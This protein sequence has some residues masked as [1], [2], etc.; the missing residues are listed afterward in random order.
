G[1]SSRSASRISAAAPVS[2]S[3][4]RP[5]RASSS[6]MP[7]LE[8]GAG[9]A[10]LRRSP[11]CAGS[12]QVRWTWRRFAAELSVEK[13]IAP[14]GGGAYIAPMGQTARREPD[15]LAAVDW[16]AVERDL[17]AAGHAVIPGIVAPEDCRA[18]SALY[19]DDTRF[20]SRVVMERH[21]FGRGEY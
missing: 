15:A 4:A 18:L 5:S 2:R 13:R 20:R 8:A 19:G 11:C 7:N 6:P 3:R 14:A 17:D 12:S 9:S 10:P 16:A 21:G 1:A